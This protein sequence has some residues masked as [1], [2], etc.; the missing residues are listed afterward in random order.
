MSYSGDSIKHQEQR[1]GCFFM[2]TILSEV[3]PHGVL[4][5]I[6]LM[7]NDVEHLF[8]GLISCLSIFFDKLS[9][10]IGLSF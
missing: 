7:A 8:M 2:M 1:K 5:F 9:I 10:Q 6:I 3:I 4:I